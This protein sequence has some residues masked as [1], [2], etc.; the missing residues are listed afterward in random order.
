MTFV[1]S[2]LHHTRLYES[3][4]S[5]WK[6]SAYACIA[7]VIRDQ[8]WLVDGDSK[9][10]P[11]V[12]ILFLAPSAQKKARPVNLAEH[13]VAEIGNV[14]V[15]SGRT[16]I[17]AILTEI[18]HS[19]TDK[20]G[21]IK[22]GGS[23]IFFAP[24]LAAGLVQDEQSVQI[25]TDIYDYKPK[26]H[27][28]NL[29]GRGKLKLENLVFSMLGASN[30]ELLRSV[31]SS[32]AIYG[33]LLGRTFLITPNEFRPANAFPQA[34]EKGFNRLIT[35]LLEISRLEGPIVYEE[36]ARDYYERWYKQYRE[37]SKLKDD[38]SGVY[39]RLPTNVKKLATLLAANEVTTCVSLA[40]VEEAI[41]ECLALLPNY[42][43]FM[44]SAGKSTIAEAGAIIMDILS[45][46]KGKLVEKKD[47]LRDHWMHFD[48]ELLTKV[49]TTFTI[50]K[51]V[52]HD[53]RGMKEFYKLTDYGLEVMGQGPKEVR[54]V[55]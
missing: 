34:D 8:V 52:E 50:A 16:S 18:G 9:L 54:D 24:E 11:N 10:Y 7:G 20:H 27:T 41:D 46:H 44:I 3:P 38:R 17:Q 21:R 22:K 30:D 43:S 33:G 36:D 29:V 37:K 6:W 49:I 2:V 12:Y 13:L 19:E 32:K 5:F 55:K 4:G 45:R 26:G 23:A 35:Q 39:G 47:L 40:H 28:T 1:D 31:Y 42:S 14:G 51:L 48:D 53:V 15:I 25:L